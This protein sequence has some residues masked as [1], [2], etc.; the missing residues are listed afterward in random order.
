[1]VSVGGRLSDIFGRRYIFAS[2]P[3]IIAV[4]AIVGA[5]SQSVGQNI[6]SGVIMGTGGGLGEMALGIVQEVVPFRFRVR[7]LGNSSRSRVQRI[8]F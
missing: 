1:M 2:A 3:A 8:C 6:A 5:T 7:M 4:G